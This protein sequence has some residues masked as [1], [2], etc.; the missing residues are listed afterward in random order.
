[1]DYLNEAVRLDDKYKLMAVEDDDLEK[2]RDEL[3]NLG[4]GEIVV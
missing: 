4:W 3:I 2:I 1:M